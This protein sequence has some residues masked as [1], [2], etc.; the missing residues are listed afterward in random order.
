MKIKRRGNKIYEK[1]GE[2]GQKQCVRSKYRI[3]LFVVGEE[4]KILL[5]RK[6]FRTRIQ[7]TEEKVRTPTC[8]KVRPGWCK[9]FAH[10]GWAYGVEPMVRPPALLVIF[11]K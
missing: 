11:A 1:R 3:F 2:P 4:T 8:C 5:G 7:T 6:G 9:E 10:D